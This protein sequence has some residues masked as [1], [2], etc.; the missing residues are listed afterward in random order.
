MPTIPDT[1]QATGLPAAPSAPLVVAATGLPAAPSSPLASG[2]VPNATTIGVAATLISG[3]IKWTANMGGVAGNTCTVW[4]DALDIV[5]PLCLVVG[6]SMGIRAANK[7]SF[8]ATGTTPAL[9]KCYAT[10]YP[11]NVFYT[12]YT[13]DGIPSLGGVLGSGRTVAWMDGTKWRIVQY[14]G[15]GTILFSASSSGVSASP[16]LATGW[17]ATT[18]SI[19]SLIFA[20]YRSTKADII[21]ACNSDRYASQVLTA[22]AAGDVSGIVATL[23]STYL[24]GGSGLEGPSQGASVFAAISPDS[25]LAPTAVY[26]P[27]TPTAPT[28]VHA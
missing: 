14:D 23:T 25:P 16:D 6:Q 15:L 18:G 8:T 22:S 5:F 20:M 19:T 1:V 7:A 26:T 13:S 27:S 3:S 11:Q 2:P 24:S 12:V 28:A 4:I 17:A 21:A 10:A 9:P